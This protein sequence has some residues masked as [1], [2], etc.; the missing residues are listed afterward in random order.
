MVQILQANPSHKSLVLK[1][2]DNFREACLS[3]SEPDKIHYSDS[4]RSHGGIIFDEVITSSKAAIFLAKEDELYVGIVTAYLIPQ[5]RKGCYMVE[6]EEMYVSPDFHG[7]GIAQLLMEAVISWT[8]SKGI[9][10]IRLESALELTRAHSF[11]E[12]F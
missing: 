12:K 5:I 11:Y 7:K 3:I 1:L 10:T 6:I 9:S 2:L 4:A 8:R